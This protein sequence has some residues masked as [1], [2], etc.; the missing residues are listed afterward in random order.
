MRATTADGA[1]FDYPPEMIR[2]MR[3]AVQ[4][5]RISFPPDLV[6]PMRAAVERFSAQLPP[7]TIPGFGPDDDD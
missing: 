4:S 5:G 7:A 3:E 6:E 2:A 1:T